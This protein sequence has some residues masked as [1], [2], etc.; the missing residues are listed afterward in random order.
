MK[1][2][3][4]LAIIAAQ[5]KDLCL[6]IY[7]GKATV[8]MGCGPEKKQITVNWGDDEAI[9]R[10]TYALNHGE[11]K[12]DGSV[13]E[14]EQIQ[15]VYLCYEENCPDLAREAGALNE[16]ELFFT[17]ESRDA[18]IKARLE[19]AKEDDF[20]VDEEI[21]GAEKLSAMIEKDES[22]DITLFR[23]EQENWSEHYDIIAKRMDI[24]V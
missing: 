4:N 14:C 10:L 1:Q 9:S 16:I 8:H 22:I 15:S 3:G 23:N 2:L 7:D 6:S 20:I 18:W 5:R 19:Q 11:Y 12:Q 17:K 13:I 21:G 24:K